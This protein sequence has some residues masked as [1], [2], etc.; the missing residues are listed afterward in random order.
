MSEDRVDLWIRNPGIIDGSGL[1]RCPDW[2]GLVRPAGGAGGRAGLALPRTHL[3]DVP[4]V[5][6]GTFRSMTAERGFLDWLVE[7]KRGVGGKMG[8]V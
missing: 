2:C 5:A 8:E 4:K 6:R 7:H 3:Q 1:L